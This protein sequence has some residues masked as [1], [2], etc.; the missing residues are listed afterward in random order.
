[1]LVSEL[2]S[3]QES[4]TAIIAEF[5]FTPAD[6]SARCFNISVT[7]DS[8]IENTEQFQGSLQPRRSEFDQSTINTTTIYIKDNDGIIESDTC[9]SFYMPLHKWG[10]RYTS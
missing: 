4:T 8:I 1:M 10:Y 9:H 5:Q 7:E 2:S 6:E 3:I